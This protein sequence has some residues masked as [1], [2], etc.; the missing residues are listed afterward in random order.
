MIVN[1]TL[2]IELTPTSMLP[3]DERRRMDAARP[4]SNGKY[5]CSTQLSN[6]KTPRIQQVPRKRWLAVRDE[7]AE[8]EVLRGEVFEVEINVLH[9]LT[10][11]TI[12]V[13]RLGG[14]GRRLLCLPDS[15]PKILNLPLQPF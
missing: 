11:F 1:K 3:L 10:T 5:G 14:V 2:F 9:L 13:R 8:V 12:A 15:L 7:L 4:K 6:R